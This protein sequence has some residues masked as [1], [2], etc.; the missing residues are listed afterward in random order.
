MNREFDKTEFKLLEFFE[1]RLSLETIRS[2]DSDELNNFI[3]EKEE[4]LMARNKTTENIQ[5]EEERKREAS[6]AKYSK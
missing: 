2:L 4:I 6:L 5:R 1:G 3:E